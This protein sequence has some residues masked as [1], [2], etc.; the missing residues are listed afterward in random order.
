MKYSEDEK[1]IKYDPYY[2]MGYECG[3]IDAE[4]D[5]MYYGFNV[6]REHKTN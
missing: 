4:H 2:R 6:A 1:K 3:S 5:L